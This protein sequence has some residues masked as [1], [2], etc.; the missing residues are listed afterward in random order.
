MAESLSLS[1][2]PSPLSL[3][4]LLSPML[5]QP[6]EK[7]VKKCTDDQLLEL[8]ENLAPD[9]ATVACQKHGSFSVQALMD[10]IHT[11]EQINALVFALNKDIMR[12]ILHSSGHFVVLRFLQRF[13]MPHCKFIL[14][15][16]EKNCLEIGTGLNMWI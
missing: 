3:L 16:I 9:I 7:L 8:L 4:S 15:V 6:T 11:I 12:M 5:I 1:L 13:P 2:S 14:D 10:T